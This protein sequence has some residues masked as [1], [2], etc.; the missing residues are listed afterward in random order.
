[1]RLAIDLCRTRVETKYSV[2]AEDVT[3]LTSRIPSD[4]R[5]EYGVLTLYFD[6]PDGSLARRAIRD[7]LHCTKVRTR[8]YPGDASVWFEVKTRW[9]CWTHKSRLQLNRDDA[10]RLIR[11]LSP[12]DAERFV[13]LQDREDGEAEARR[14][15]REL[16]EGGLRPVGAVFADRRTFLARQDQVRITL[17]QQIAYYR[18]GADPYS[19]PLATAPGLLLRSEPDLVL[20]VK[21]GGELPA[22][23]RDLVTGLR[24][25]KYS[26]FRNLVHSL[27]EAR[28]SSQRVDRL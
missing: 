20:E 4:E 23:G 25:S 2:A 21:H 15:L 27:A 19:L 22:W 26:K 14:H 9:G 24:R 6:R 12:S 5:E 11:G 1:M 28:R 16:A 8:Q 13:P 3:G 17:D 18:L 10:A 7:P